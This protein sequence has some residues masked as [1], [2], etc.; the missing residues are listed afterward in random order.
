MRQTLCMCGFA[1]ELFK[2]EERGRLRKKKKR[3]KEAKQK[4]E[5]GKKR[6]GGKRGKGGKEQRQKGKKLTV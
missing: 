4:G 2:K 5:R 1:F 6:K 3:G